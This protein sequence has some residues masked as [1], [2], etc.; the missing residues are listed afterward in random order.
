VEF[1]D[2]LR[3]RNA[4]VPADLKAGF[5]GMDLYSLHTSIE[6]VLGYLSG[7]DPEAAERARHRYAC[8]DSFGGDPQAYGYA[9]ASG[10]A[11]T[12]EQEVVN[13]LLEL[14]RRQAEILSHD[15]QAALEEFFFAEQNALLI[16]NA[17]AYYR[18][19]FRGRVSSWNLRDR[20]M[21]E[22]LASL[23]GHLDQQRPGTRVVVWAHN[24]HLGDARATEMGRRGEW[25][26]GQLVRERFGPD[27]VLVG[28]S[29]HRGTVTAAS[30]WGEPAERKTVR[31]ALEGSYEALFHEAGTDRLLLNLRAPQTLRE[32]L[33]QPRLQRAIGVIYRPETERWS[34]YFEAR[35]S[36]QF[37]AVLHF[38]E[39][40]AVEPLERASSWEVGE[41]PET[42]PSG[43]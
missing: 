15:G 31:P 14:R 33:R 21:V 22:S 20:H 25:N 23:V 30:G 35:L 16:K 12:C 37:D 34:H 28:F 24:S 8:F 36:E 38:D 41:L 13:Q 5:Y 19:L 40:R 1:V 4:R 29:T 7:I 32:G 27:V 11:E 42:Y 2:W 43:V 18:S 6:A 39:T 3:A 9:A 17:E 10:T 26:V